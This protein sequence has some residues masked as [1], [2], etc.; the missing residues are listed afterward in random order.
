MLDNVRRK[1]GGMLAVYLARP[2]S[3][4]PNP[5]VLPSLADLERALAPGDVLLVD[6]DS[7]FSVAVKYL[8]QSTWSHATLYVGR[9]RRAA[10][11]TSEEAM[12][13]E[14]DVVAGVT[15]VPLSKYAGFRTR[16]CR[17]TGLDDAER[18]Q[19]V[20]FA[21]ARLGHTYDLRN[22]VDLARYLITTPPVRESRRRRLLALGSGDPTRAICSTLIAQA[23]Q[24]VRYPILPEVERIPNG[25]CDDCVDE[26]LQIRHHSLF[27]PR[28]FDLSPF[29]GVV[30]PRVEA[31]ADHHAIQWADD[32]GARHAPAVSETDGGSRKV[33]RTT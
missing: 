3:N 24:S 13:L 21:C 28:D 22:V 27:T 18:D 9:R 16:I 25:E 15:L 8:T 12:L 32:G 20:A 29:F 17:A 19:V 4:R 6:G 2:R 14:A 30:K 7:K 5:G 31:Y 23:F 33:V 26:I 11:A 1:I 10:A